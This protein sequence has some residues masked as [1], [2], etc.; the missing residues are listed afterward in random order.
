MTPEEEN[1]MERDGL[2]GPHR[3]YYLSSMKNHCRELALKE[4]LIPMWRSWL[5][6]WAE[7]KEI[8]KTWH[9]TFP[10]RKSDVKGREAEVPHKDAPAHS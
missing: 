8:Q 7:L 9:E 1:E 4:G 6:N 5:D 3:D 10:T 2:N